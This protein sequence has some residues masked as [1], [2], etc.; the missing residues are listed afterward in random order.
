MSRRDMDLE[1]SSGFTIWVQ[2][3]L[4]TYLPQVNPLLGRSVFQDL[5]HRI[6]LIT[7]EWH[8]GW[9]KKE[10][11]G[12]SWSSHCCYSFTPYSASLWA[13]PNFC[14]LPLAGSKLLL[15]FSLPFPHKSVSSNVVEGEG[16][17]WRD[18]TRK[19]SQNSFL[20]TRLSLTLC[21]PLHLE[22]LYFIFPKISHDFC[23]RFWEPSISSGFLGRDPG[24]EP[25]AGARP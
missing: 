9:R 19:F 1:G 8:P 4:P 15:L 11:S 7:Q 13:F 25:T 16:L 3:L 24:K 10:F 12:S 21:F 20:N 22:P 5:L 18:I 23:T 6:Q 14:L 17:R 2:Q